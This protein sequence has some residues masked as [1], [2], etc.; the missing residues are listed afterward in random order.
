MLDVNRCGGYTCNFGDDRPPRG[1]EYTGE[2][3]KNEIP[4]LCAPNNMIL[5]WEYA[6]DPSVTRVRVAVPVGSGCRTTEDLRSE[7]GLSDCV[8][9]T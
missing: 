5:N 1:G 4:L 9:T 8:T 3:T 2:K 6:L 7:R